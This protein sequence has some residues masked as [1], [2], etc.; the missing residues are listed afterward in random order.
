MTEIAKY[1][2][3]RT[4]LICLMIANTVNPKAR[5]TIKRKIILNTRNRTHQTYRRVILIGPT[6]VTIYKRDANIRIF[7]GKRIL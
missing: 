6:T 3:A 1:I 5:N 4:N 7:I 2:E